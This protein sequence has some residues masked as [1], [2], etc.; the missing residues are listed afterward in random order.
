MNYSEI[1]KL[2]TNPYIPVIMPQPTEVMYYGIFYMPTYNSF[3]KAIGM[4]LGIFLFSK[5]FWMFIYELKCGNG[6]DYLYGKFKREK[7]TFK[8][9]KE[10]ILDKFRKT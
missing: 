4:V 2:E 9:I 7:L 3:L 8:K 5:L 6:E 1:I 10:V